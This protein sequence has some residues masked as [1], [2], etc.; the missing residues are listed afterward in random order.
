MLLCHFKIFPPL[1]ILCQFVGD[2]FVEDVFDG[3]GDYGLPA[4]AVSDFFF[5]PIGY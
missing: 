5:F 4:A 2:L 3:K 1:D